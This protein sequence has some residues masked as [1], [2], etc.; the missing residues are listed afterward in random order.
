MFRR[1]LHTYV[2]VQNPP[3]SIPLFNEPRSKTPPSEIGRTLLYARKTFSFD[4]NLQISP[5]SITHRYLRSNTYTRLPSLGVTTAHKSIEKSNK[6]F[7]THR[8]LYLR[9]LCLL[10]YNPLSIW[11]QRQSINQNYLHIFSKFYAF[12]HFFRGFLV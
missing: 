3:V 12:Y 1:I 9:S 10:R 7:V 11:F 4:L 5:H 6:R 8:G 2:N